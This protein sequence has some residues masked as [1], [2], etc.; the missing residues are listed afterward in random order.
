MDRRL[1]EGEAS[2]DQIKRVKAELHCEHMEIKMGGPLV[3]VEG[4]LRTGPDRSVRGD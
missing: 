3:I 1:P 2:S 4:W